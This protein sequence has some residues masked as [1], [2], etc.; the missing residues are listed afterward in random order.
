MPTCGRLAFLESLRFFTCSR[1]SHTADPANKAILMRKDSESLPRLLTAASARVVA[2]SRASKI[3]R[4]SWRASEQL[5][6][7]NVKQA[8]YILMKVFVGRCLFPVK[9]A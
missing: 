2:S 5:A 6:Q 4:D 9:F 1:T 3:V 8:A 7:L